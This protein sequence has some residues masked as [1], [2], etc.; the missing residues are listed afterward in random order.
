MSDPIPPSFADLGLHAELLTAL[1]T[2]G[3]DTATPIQAQSI[4]LI[5]AGRDLAAQA[6]TGSGKTLA[7]AL[8]L[9]HTMQEKDGVQVLVLCPTRELAIQVAGSFQEAA[10]DLKPR[11]EAL[12]VIGGVDIEKQQKKLSS[13]VQVV[14]AT[15]GRLLDLIERGSL[16]LSALRALVLDE[17][18]KL[19]DVGFG[20]E[21]ERLTSLL[22]TERQTL[23]FSATLPQRVVALSKDLLRSPEHILVDAPT[24]AADGVHQRVI[25]VPSLSRR[26]ALEHLLTTH[27]W[28]QVMVFVATQRGCD[29]L[30]RKLRVSGTN[31]LNLHGGLEQRQRNYALTH[32]RSGAARVL[33]TTDIA[34]RGIDV[35]KLAAVVNF[36]LPRS[37]ADYIHRIGRTARAGEKGEAVSFVDH[38]TEPH[39]KLIEKRNGLR[40]D[41]EQLPGFE[42]DPKAPNKPDI[43]GGVKG[44][45]KSKKD[46]LRE[47]AAKKA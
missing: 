16:E 43:N 35:P 23:L 10:R 2:L 40:L 11:V 27:D 28:A 15:P 37:T 20:E 33:V 47:A 30:S 26:M 6:Q 32:F 18:D 19:L 17:A 14:V 38:D 3:F 9:L 21:L 4:P 22:P 5:L 29:N 41:R 25:Q 24:L 1:D 46:R 44:K 39:M 13:G 36:D 7:F 12:V 45:R 8:P 34:A 31:A 42:L